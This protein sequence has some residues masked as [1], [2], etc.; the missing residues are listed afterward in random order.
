MN[1][2]ETD[3][4]AP[5]LEAHYDLLTLA[6][7]C[8]ETQ[9][10][11]IPT[12]DRRSVGVLAYHIAQGYSVETELIKAVVSGQPLPAIYL[13]RVA[14]DQ[15]NAAHAD[16]HHGCTKQE[17]LALLHQN[18]AATLEY[19][20]GLSEVELSRSAH[21]PILAARFGDV[22]VVRQ[23]VEE[24]LPGHIRMHLSEMRAVPAGSL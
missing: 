7:S 9:W 22:V 18:A 12:M 24:L 11:A 6:E 19:I 17:A 23:L 10:R 3:L 1:T 13:G 20:R 15:F 2:Q 21:I 4:A 5:F 8:A 14:L 16:Q